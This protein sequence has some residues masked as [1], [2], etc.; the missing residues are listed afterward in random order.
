MVFTRSVEFLEHWYFSDF[1]WPK[2]HAVHQL[3]SPV[4]SNT[5][6]EL[7][8]YHIRIKCHM[9]KPT[10]LLAFHLLQTKVLL[11]GV[12]RQDNIN[13]FNMRLGNFT[14]TVL[15]PRFMLYHF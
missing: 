11:T 5:S 9:L 14:I 4:P 13:L 2:S 15:G 6:K 12:S 3:L 10:L 7:P 8:I 1:H